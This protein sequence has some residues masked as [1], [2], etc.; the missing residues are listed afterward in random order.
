M[1]KKRKKE[2]VP[3]WYPI[4]FSEDQIIIIINNNLS[5]I[6]FLKYKFIDNGILVTRREK[7]ENTPS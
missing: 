2:I 7:N 1:P 5:A 3:L 6:F 4:L